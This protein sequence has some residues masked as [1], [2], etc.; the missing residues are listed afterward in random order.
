[1][2]LSPD[3][4]SYAVVTRAHRSE[5]PDV[6]GDMGFVSK[7]GD[8]LLIVLLDALG[9]GIMA[10]EVAIRAKAYLLGGGDVSSLEGLMS[11]LH[12]HLKGT[13]GAVVALCSFNCTSRVLRYVGVGNITAKVYSDKPFT[14]LPKGGIVGYIMSDPREEMFILPIGS[15]FILHSDG[16]PAHV[17]LNASGGV[18]DGDAQVVADRVVREFGKDND[19]VGCVVLKV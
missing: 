4:A 16:V 9:H 13:R 17:D 7:S 10:Q 5:S 14:L 1:M 15:V 11:G 6:C 3:S 19:D 12:E 8:E 2:A 18:V